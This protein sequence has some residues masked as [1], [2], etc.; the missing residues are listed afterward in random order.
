MVILHASSG[1]FAGQVARGTA[2]GAR[3][4]GFGEIRVTAFASPL[5]DPRPLLRE[6]AAAEPDLLVG[7]GAFPDD[8]A[9]A[10]QRAL[11]P[12]RTAVALVGAGLPAFGE[13]VGRL[14]EGIVGPSQWEPTPGPAPRLGPDSAWFV[15]AF[16]RA[17]HR[18]PGY[19]AAQAFALG[20][21]VEECRRRAGGRLAGP[22]LLEAARALDTTTLYGAFRLDPA[23]GR[24]VG[25]RVRLVQWRGGRKRVIDA[26]A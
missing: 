14:A 11:L 20:V 10:R 9:I 4:A 18:T 6:A 24:Q 5:G 15:D 3:A 7:V 25:H 8:V 19:P 21:I 2:E 23:T 1:T 17:F 16:E 26:A 13:E 12:A 22:A